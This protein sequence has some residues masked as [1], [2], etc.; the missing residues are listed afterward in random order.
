MTCVL[1][2][3]MGMHK[4]RM[5]THEMCMGLHEVCMSTH[6]PLLAS[7]E[8]VW[9]VLVQKDTQAGHDGPAK[10]TCHENMQ[11][12]I[13]WKHGFK[14]CMWVLYLDGGAQ[15]RAHLT[16]GLACGPTDLRMGPCT[17]L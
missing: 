12:K 8:V 10:K 1:Q 14:K 15:V 17:G 3:R 2:A 5:D 13:T 16:K 9:P 11:Y 6:D 4:V 7:H